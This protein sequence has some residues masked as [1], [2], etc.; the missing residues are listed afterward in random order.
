MVVYIRLREAPLVF[1]ELSY[2]VLLIL[3]T[4]RLFYAHINSFAYKK[5]VFC[6][7]EDRKQTG[8]STQGIP[9]NGES[10][11]MPPAARLLLSDVTCQRLPGCIV[12]NQE[13]R[14][15]MMQYPLTIEQLRQQFAD[16]C[17]YHARKSFFFTI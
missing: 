8:S 9:T 2:C 1:P 16:F 3:C 5:G 7:A 15:G 6:R 11:I 4:I 10:A 13:R 12:R 14:C 17:T